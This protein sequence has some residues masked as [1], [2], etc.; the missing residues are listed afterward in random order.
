MLPAGL[1]SVLFVEE[2]A[3]AVSC[4]Q[5]RV[6]TSWLCR[7]WE[8][9]CSARSIQE[10]CCRQDWWDL[11]RRQLPWEHM[12]PPIYHVRG[13]TA[14]R[15]SREVEK[16]LLSCAERSRGTRPPPE[17][18][19]EQPHISADV[20]SPALQLLEHP[21]QRGPKGIWALPEA[22]R[23]KGLDIWWE[24]MWSYLT[25]I[26]VPKVL[27]LFLCHGLGAQPPQLKLS[28]LVHYY[29]P[30]K[31]KSLFTSLTGFFI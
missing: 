19:P 12:K 24:Q 4:S 31:P 6:L 9:A 1:E 29:Y 22:S 2:M 25:A 26:T 20:L 14:N 3:G 7:H 27:L 13:S 30:N 23:E 15:A 10:G 21:K 16:P 8:Q 11:W 5:P 28:T 17:H 18:R